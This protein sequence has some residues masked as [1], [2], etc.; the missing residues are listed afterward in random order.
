MKSMEV[1]KPVF[2][3]GDTLNLSSKKI[4]KKFK[5]EINKIKYPEKNISDTLFEVEYDTPLYAHATLEPL[6]FTVNCTENFCEVWGP[7]QSQTSLHFSSHPH[8]KSQATPPI[9]KKLLLINLCPVAA[10]QRA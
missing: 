6:N 10:S 8:G 5:E 7:T 4:E 3:G 2:E 9:R 1:L